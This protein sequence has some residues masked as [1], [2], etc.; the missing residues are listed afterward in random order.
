MAARVEATDDKYQ[1]TEKLKTSAKSVE[2]NLTAAGGYLS[3]RADMLYKGVSQKFNS[4]SSSGEKN[5]ED[6]GNRDDR[7]RSSEDRNGGI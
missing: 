3:A 6:Y 2:K 7:F 1:V 4:S 5:Y